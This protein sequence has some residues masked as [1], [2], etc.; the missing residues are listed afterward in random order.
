V[1]LLAGSACT[2]IRGHIS[3]FGGQT[4]SLAPPVISEIIPRSL[5]VAGG[6]TINVHGSGFVPN[7]SVYV[8]D[9]KCLNVHVISP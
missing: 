5:L 6:E 2:V 8:G 1:F 9:D 3:Y 4:E 7:A